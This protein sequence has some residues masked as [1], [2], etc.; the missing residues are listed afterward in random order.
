MS[1]VAV[2]IDDNFRL[3]GALLAAGA[4]PEHEQSVKPYKPHRTAE[5]AHKF[6]AAQAGHAA[7]KGAQT[8]VGQGEGLSLLFGHALNG[9]WPASIPAA[10]FK[11][12]AQPETFW[13][14]S[15]ADWQEAEFDAKLVLAHGNLGQFLDDLLGPQTRALVLFPNLLFPGLIPLAAASASEIVAVVPPPKAWG[16][17][18]PWRYKERRDEVLAEVSGTFAQFI[19]EDGLPAAHAALKPRAAAFGVAAAVLFVREAES[20][21][22]GDQYMVMEKKAHGLPTLPAL[23]EALAPLLA[24]RRAGKHKSF[25]DYLPQLAAALQG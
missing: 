21:E 12:A 17:S 24:E 13:A 2:R 22:A 5:H 8:L 14:E 4:W 3:A 11:S 7:V 10:D 16:T 20:Q 19:F 23:V 15:Q 6:F 18:P 9:D 1:T 25:A